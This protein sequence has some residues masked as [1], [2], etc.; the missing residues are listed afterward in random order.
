VNSARESSDECEIRHPIVRLLVDDEL[1]SAGLALQ[2][3]RSTQQPQ[4]LPL[5]QTCVGIIPL[6]ARRRGGPLRHL[7]GST[8]HVPCGQ[9]TAYTWCKPCK[10]YK[11]CTPLFSWPKTS[12][13]AYKAF[14]KV[15][16]TPC[17]LNKSGVHALFALDEGCTKYSGTANQIRVSAPEYDISYKA[18]KLFL[19]ME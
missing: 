5:S 12:C 8:R 11:A 7:C 13:K 9:T 19:C 1:G 4:R 14:E 2:I 17:T 16:C 15:P 3:E 10:A 6:G 18:N